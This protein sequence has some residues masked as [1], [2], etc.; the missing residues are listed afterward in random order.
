MRS[1]R[2][3][4]RREERKEKKKKEEEENGGDKAAAARPAS[5]PQRTTTTEA[6]IIVHVNDRLGTKAAIPCLASDPVSE[7]CPPSLS[8][9]LFARPPSTHS[10]HGRAEMQMKLTYRNRS[11]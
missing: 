3:E 10:L 1:P 2:S 4:K 7:Y 5:A 6:M 8:P 9:I 11:I